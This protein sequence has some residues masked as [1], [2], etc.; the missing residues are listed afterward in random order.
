MDNQI[1]EYI[2]TKIILLLENKLNQEDIKSIIK[3]TKNYEYSID[4]KKLLKFKIN[5]SQD[6]LKS[7]C[8]K[9][10]E[11][12][13]IDTKY[14]QIISSITHHEYTLVFNKHRQN[15]MKNVLTQVLQFTDNYG[16]QNIGNNKTI[17]IE[18]S[19]PNIAKPFHMGHLRST[20][21]GN[22]IKNLYQSFGYKVVSINY[23]GDWGKQYGLLGVGYQQWGS[24]EQLITNPIK[25]LYEVYVKA[26]NALAVQRDEIFYANQNNKTTTNTKITENKTENINKIT[27]EDEMINEIEKD[28][29][30][31]VNQPRAEIDIAAQE[32]FR[33]MEQG[34]PTEIELWKKLRDLSINQLSI[35]YSRLGV[36]FDNYSGESQTTSKISDVIHLLSENKFFKKDEKGHFM[37]L[38]HLNLGRASILKSDDT[39]LYL[40]RDIAEIMRR[41]EMYNDFEK[42]IYVVGDPQKYHFN[43]LFN[44]QQELH[45]NENTTSKFI[46]IGFGLV[47][48][49]KTRKGRAVFLS[50]FLDDAKDRMMDVMKENNDK[51]ENI[52]D[53]NW[54]ADQLGISALIVWDMFRHRLSNYEYNWNKMSSF[55][56]ETGPYLQY[57]HAR[58]FNIGQKVHDQIDIHNNNIELNVSIFDTC[59]EAY[60]LVK[61]INEYPYILEECLQDHEAVHLVNYLMILAKMIAKCYDV[62]RV[63]DEP[64]KNIAENRYILYKCAKYVLANG[65]RMIGL[66]PI[67]NM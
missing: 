14:N 51:Y 42:C 62:I 31:N 49:M 19:S 36:K 45:P 16:S 23:L 44:I 48:N 30:V 63:K 58:L 6:I 37:D 43:Q 29:I 24:E 7:W 17:L 22:F 57:A 28:E 13:S 59:D 34:N 10:N 11:Q 38:E 66:Q 40:T 5:I 20:I 25:H 4:V 35:I 26:N 41:K 53:P 52:Q 65:M 15:F 67:N 21:I 27:E 39:T 9:L 61:I 46:H 64:N 8:S 55:K 33:K 47:K 2:L 54:T 1:V 32:Y 56:G 18:Y 3:K 12:L 50:D 60:E